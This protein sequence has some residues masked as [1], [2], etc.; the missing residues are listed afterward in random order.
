MAGVARAAES[1]H[2]KVYNP[3][4]LG[5]KDI[6]HKYAD[7]SLRRRGALSPRQVRESPFGTCARACRGDMNRNRPPPAGTAMAMCNDGQDGQCY[8]L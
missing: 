6:S 4:M 2:V 3:F 5:N 8:L 1:V 7:V